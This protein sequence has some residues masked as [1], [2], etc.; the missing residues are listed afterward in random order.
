MEM[1]RS[2][3]VAPWLKL[4][5]APLLASWMEG[6]HRKR[7]S[8]L[9]TGLSPGRYVL[10]TRVRIQ[11]NTVLCANYTSEAVN[12][13]SNYYGASS[14]FVLILARTYGAFV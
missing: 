12:S 7:F 9:G 4:H 8:F 10:G 3:D 1:K 11:R 14:R 6:Q 5:V 2:V 13:Q